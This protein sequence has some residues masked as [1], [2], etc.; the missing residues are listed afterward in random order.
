[1][2]DSLSG[3]TGYEGDY[4]T[5]LTET[6]Y[7]FIPWDNETAAE[8]GELLRQDIIQVAVNVQ[9]EDIDRFLQGDMAMS[10]MPGIRKLASKR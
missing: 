4:N 10:G 3:S 6:N 9:H 8:D 7:L 1:M 5:L 2:S